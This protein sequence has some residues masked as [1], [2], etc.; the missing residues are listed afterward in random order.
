[1]CAHAV[2]K[3]EL[4]PRQLLKDYSPTTFFFLISSR[5]YINKIQ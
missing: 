4:A 5:N 2:W 3:R 1:M